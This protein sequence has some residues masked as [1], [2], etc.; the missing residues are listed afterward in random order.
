MGIYVF[1]TEALLEAIEKNPDI[2]DLDFGMHII[3]QM[4]EEKNVYAYEYDDYWMDVGTYDS[5]METN[6]ELCHNGSAFDLYDNKWKVYTKSE[7]L[8]P[9]KIGGNATIKTSL[10]SNGAVIDGTVEECVLSPGVKIGKGT[11]IK[12]SVILNDVVIGENCRIENA[13]IDKDTVIGDNCVIGH[14]SDYTP[15]IDNPKV[16]S[17]GLNVFGKKIKVPANT[18]FERNIRVFPSAKQDSFPA[19]VKS[20]STIK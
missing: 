5:Y 7:D 6:L 18:I 11:Y 16:L 12:K 1:S 2:V 15:N 14:G 8:P 4:I 19:V 17:S 20:G 9:V 3:P 10:V 13:I